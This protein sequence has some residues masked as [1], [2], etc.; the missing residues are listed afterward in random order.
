M[1]IRA[2][3]LCISPA[4]FAAPSSAQQPFAYD[5]C[6]V[7]IND[8]CEKLV[9]DATGEQ[10]TGDF[11]PFVLGDH[12]HV[13][14]WASFSFFNCPFPIDGEFDQA[15]GF[16]SLIELCP[17][18]DPSQHFCFGDGTSGSACPCSN[19][20]AAGEGCA[21]SQGHGA[22]LSASGSAVHANDDLVLH[23]SQARPLVPSI[24]VQG[25][26]TISVP[27]RDGIYCMGS[28][29]VRMEVVM[30][31]ANGAGASAGSIVTLGS[32]PGP[33]STRNYQQWY[34]DP[35]LSPCGT[36]SNFTNAVRIHWI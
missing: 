23:V 7:I 15:G 1:L 3:P 26:T 35:N 34:R 14:G 36:G 21:N 33:G 9:D 2:I 12:V 30:L 10:Y 31:D 29:T 11:S 8:G 13:V 16:I 32:V 19:P 25:A 18:V 24:L 20:G 22:L 17:E 5:G 28:P 4:L 6:G 27:F